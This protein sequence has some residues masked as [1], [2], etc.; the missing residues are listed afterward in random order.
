MLI[1]FE[2]VLRIADRHEQP[3][4]IIL[5]YPVAHEMGHV[6]LPTPAHSPTGIMRPHWDGDDMRH[7]F[8][9]SLTFTPAQVALIRS[10][11][12]ECCKKESK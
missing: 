9:R 5:A 7:I 10:K 4:G 12:A 3:V 6:L 2:D 11:V 8:D 1:F